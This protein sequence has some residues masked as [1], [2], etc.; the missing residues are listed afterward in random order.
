LKTPKGNKKKTVSTKYRQC[1]GQTGR[2][3][4]QHYI[5]AIQNEE[6]GLGC[7]TPLI[8]W[9][10]VL[11]VEEIGVPVENHRPVVSHRK[12]VSHNVVSST[13]PLSKIRAH[14]V[15]DDRH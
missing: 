8:L 12:T 10:S 6:V 4:V 9:L 5:N 7:L 11:L 13:P 2:E 3:Q 14:N 1:N 15:S